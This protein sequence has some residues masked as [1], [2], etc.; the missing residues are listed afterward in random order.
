MST[1]PLTLPIARLRAAGCKVSAV[2]G[3]A[4]EI[5]D[6]IYRVTLPEG[7]TGPGSD[8]VGNASI[9]RHAF[10]ADGL[11]VSGFAYR[12]G[13]HTPAAVAEEYRADVARALEVVAD[14][15]EQEA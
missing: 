12:P 11:I 4:P 1:N 9:R 10:R 6:F 8:V 3:H 13:I 2:I 14:H 5:G 7:A 15:V